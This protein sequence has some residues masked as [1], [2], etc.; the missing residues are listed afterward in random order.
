MRE[1]VR[2][3]L[4]DFIY[5]R[6][7]YFRTGR[8]SRRSFRSDDTPVLRPRPEGFTA[9][10]LTT[11]PFLFMD[12]P[13]T[14]L[15]LVFNDFLCLPGKSTSVKAA[16]TLNVHTNNIRSEGMME[17]AGKTGCKTCHMRLENAVLAFSGF[18]NLRLGTRFQPEGATLHEIGFYMNNEKDLR[19]T[20]P[21]TPAWFGE[22]MARQPEFAECMV[23][24]AEEFVY[25]GYPIPPEIHRTILANFRMN[26]DFLHVIEQLVSAWWLGELS[27]DT[28]NAS[29]EHAFS[30]KQ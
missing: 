1:T 15:A 27:S 10:L 14:S 29:Q 20:G 7:D 19:A 26:E 17:L 18:S 28:D 2:S 13:R 11:P 8:F 22:V 16:Q 3:D 21:A 25:G 12:E 30:P 6:A 5:E 24:K 4:A 23:K 9:G